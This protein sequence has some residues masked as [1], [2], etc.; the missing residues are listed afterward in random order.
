MLTYC[1]QIAHK[2][3]G[4]SVVAR[5]LLTPPYAAFEKAA[6]AYCAKYGITEEQLIATLDHK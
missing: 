6:Q 2:E 4:H 5:G 1:A 3:M